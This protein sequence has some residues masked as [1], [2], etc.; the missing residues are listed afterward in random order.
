M[1]YLKL[2]GSAVIFSTALCFSSCSDESA[3]DSNKAAS[4]VKNGE[5]CYG[6]LD[7]VT[8]SR[9]S[10]GLE[11]ATYTAT[12]Y[13]LFYMDKTTDGKW[14]KITEI[15]CGYESHT[16]GR[17]IINDGK[18]WT[19]MS[20]F[21]LSSGPTRFATALWAVNLKTKS[22]YSVYITR[23]FELDTEERIL[24]INDKK[25]GV[26]AADKEELTLSYESGYITGGTNET[27]KWL[28]VTSYKLSEPLVFNEGKDLAFDSDKEAYDWLIEIFEEVFGESV[29]LNS[30]QKNIIFDNPYLYL[31]ELKEER[32][33]R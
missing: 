26:I 16:P 13:A 29:D 28:D 8:I 24:T 32:G 1:K 25:F 19:P 15:L 11:N 3:P 17:V 22:N 31:S 4:Y 21:S 14:E 27:G 7:Y 33:K 9:Y 30:L 12:D 18:L 6:T 23:P 5:I 2:L 10:D 20:V